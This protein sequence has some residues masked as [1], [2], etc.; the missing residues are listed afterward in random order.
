VKRN[1]WFDFGVGSFFIL[2]LAAFLFLASI[3]S[4]SRAAEQGYKLSARFD[5]VSGLAK[6]SVV[7]LSGVIIGRVL[8]I[9]VLPDTYSAFVQFEVDDVSLR[10]PTDSTVGVYTDGVL[11]A[12]YLAISPGFSEDF[13]AGG[14][15]IIRTKSSIVLENLL[16]KLLVIM[17]DKK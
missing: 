12:K 11:G 6:N 8:D 1:F 10:I 17:G 3:T 13:L 9:R 7:R 5:D 14:D 16:G 4:G 2:G 15:E